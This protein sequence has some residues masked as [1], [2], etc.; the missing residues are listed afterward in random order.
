M[1]SPAPPEDGR[2]DDD[3][4][5]LRLGL[6]RRPPAPLPLARDEKRRSVATDGY[7]GVDMEDLWLSR[8]WSLVRLEHC[9]F[10]YCLLA[11]SSFYMTKLQCP[12]IRTKKQIV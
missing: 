8:L 7:S 1:P 9:L 12:V 6:F 2:G 4:A 10:G 3:Q 5:R 11:S